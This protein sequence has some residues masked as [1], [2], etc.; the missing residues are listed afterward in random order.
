[1]VFFVTVTNTAFHYTLKRDTGNATVQAWNA[2]CNRVIAANPKINPSYVDTVFFNMIENK[3]VHI[4]QRVAY[5][6]DEQ[7]IWGESDII[8]LF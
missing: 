3:D 6:L 7:F 4:I 2:E 5:N 1:M 8:V